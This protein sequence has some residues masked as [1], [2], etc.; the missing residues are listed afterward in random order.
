MLAVVEGV[1]S[2]GSLCLFRRGKKE[3]KKH[4]TKS[5]PE[6]PVKERKAGSPAP[7]KPREHRKK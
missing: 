2:S 7:E 6:M 1:A 4:R 3:K 5:P